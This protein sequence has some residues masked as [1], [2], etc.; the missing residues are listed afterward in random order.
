MEQVRRMERPTIRSRTNLREAASSYGVI[1]IRRQT[2]FDGSTRVR[3]GFAARRRRRP[4]PGRAV[5]KCLTPYD[6]A[7]RADPDILATG[8]DR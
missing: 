1:V 2:L 8:S 6:D 7:H 4:D 3:R 5:K